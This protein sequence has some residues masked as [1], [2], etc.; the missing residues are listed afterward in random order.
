MPTLTWKVR[1]A[2]SA[3]GAT[4][5]TRPVARTLRVVGEGDLHHRVARARPDELLG[6]VE[7]GVASALAGDLHDHLPGPDHLARLG[8]ACGDGARGVGEQDRCS[9]A[10]PARLRSCA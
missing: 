4:S 9:S 10:V 2:G 5:R 6:H 7:H 3:C 1:V 8:A